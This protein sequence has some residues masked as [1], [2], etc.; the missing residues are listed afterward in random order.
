LD[1]VSHDTDVKYCSLYA[2][3][4]WGMKIGINRCEAPGRAARNHSKKTIAALNATAG[5]RAAGGQM[6]RCTIT[7]RQCPAVAHLRGDISLHVFLYII[8][9]NY[10]LSALLR[11][12]LI[13]HQVIFHA[14]RYSCAYSC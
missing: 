10:I 12:L 1:R 9:R 7:E 4:A 2:T 6:P 3:S 5:R 13:C 8:P 14:S 11:G